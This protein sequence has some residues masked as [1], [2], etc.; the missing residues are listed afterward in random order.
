MRS[1]DAAL[2]HL[3]QFPHR[4]V[5]RALAIDIVVGAPDMRATCSRVASFP[6]L[7]ASNNSNSIGI[8][9]ILTGCLDRR[10]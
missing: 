8:R 7:R 3:A 6:R 2:Q 4:R 1:I 5:D 10:S 9:S